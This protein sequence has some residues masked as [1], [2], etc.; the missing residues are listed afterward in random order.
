MT[1]TTLAAR[2]NLDATERKIL[3]LYYTERL[4]I[5]ET[6]AVL[7]MTCF[8]VE[9]LRKSIVVRTRELLLRRPK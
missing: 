3:M 8:E 9:S 2:L 6:A 4:T 5:A 7:S 1:A